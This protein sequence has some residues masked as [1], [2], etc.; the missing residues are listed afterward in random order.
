MWAWRWRIIGSA[1]S[2]Y[3]NCA[4]HYGAFLHHPEYRARINTS[5]PHNTAKSH[6]AEQF[7]ISS[8]N[9]LSKSPP[10][11]RPCQ[12]MVISHATLSR[13]TKPPQPPSPPPQPARPPSSTPPPLS[14]PLHSAP[15]SLRLRYSPSRTRASYPTSSRALYR[16]STTP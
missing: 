2:N 15:Y 12:R 3:R 5:C 9:P 8:H 11:I 7:L 1:K 16:S 10:K 6:E 13:L 4:F 14:P